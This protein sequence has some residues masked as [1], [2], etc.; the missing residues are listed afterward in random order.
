ML[1][2]DNNLATP[3]IVGGL[4]RDKAF[5]IP[6]KVQDIDI[7]TG[8]KDSLALSLLANEKWSGAP[9]KTYDDGHGTLFFDNVKV[10]FSNNY[11]FPKV[12]DELKKNN[13]KPTDM[14]K[15]L[16][17]RDFT[18]NT[19]LQPLDLDKDPI[20]LTG[21]AM[22]DVENKILRTPVNPNLTIGY[23]VRRILRA[24]KLILKLNLTMDKELEAA[25]IKFRRG[26]KALPLIM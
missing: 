14:K 8:N 1:A 10:D 17:S 11:N 2:K 7:T 20:D 12:E 18:V 3:Y 9:F 21:K 19:L 24:M 23:D 5:G 15:E 13:I 25:I 26:I 4:P 16:Y 6:S 22:S